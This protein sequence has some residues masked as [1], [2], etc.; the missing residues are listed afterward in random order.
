MGIDAGFDMYPRL[1]KGIVDRQNWGRFI[2]FIKEYY[3]DDTQVEIEPN[4]INFKAGEH[5]RLPFEGHKFL[6]FSSKVSG[7]TAADTNV[8][9]YIDTVTRI[10]QTR[11]GSRIRFWHEG[12]D[13]FGVY[14]WNEVYESL[15]SYE[16]PDELETA[17]SIAQ[18][19]SGTDPIEELGVAPFEIKDILGKGKGLVAR[20]NISKGTR[21]VCEEP[22]LTVGPMPPDELER[23]LATKLKAISRETQRQFLSLHNNL[24]GK[25]PFSGIFKTNALPCGSGSSIGGVYPTLCLINH[26]CMPNAHNNWNSAEEHETIYAIRSIKKGDEI[27]ISDNRRVQIQNLDEAIGDPFRMMSSPQESLRDC[28]SLIQVLDQEFDGCASAL[29]ARLY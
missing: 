16:Q 13:E 22:L 2:D 7:S 23:F 5:P 17:S 15:R 26:S 11:F 24:P 3:K 12:A 8:D 9:S 6:R 10:A 14:N 27:T 20:F 21:L 1:S 4:Y 25:N 28:Y 19:L 18:L 29:I